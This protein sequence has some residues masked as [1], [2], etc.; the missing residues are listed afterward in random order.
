MSNTENVVKDIPRNTRDKFSTE[1]KTRTVLNGLP[2]ERPV[3][4]LWQQCGI[5]LGI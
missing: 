2:A 4:E 3:V 1:E 5:W